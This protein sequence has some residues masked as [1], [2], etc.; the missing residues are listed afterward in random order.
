MSNMDNT[1][2]IERLIKLE[3]ERYERLLHLVETKKTDDAFANNLGIL[4]RLMPSEYK[5]YIDLYS[6]S[7]SIKK[8]NLDDEVYAYDYEVSFNRDEETCRF[9]V[10]TY[11][12]IP[13]LYNNV[14]KVDIKN[15][16]DLKFFKPTIAKDTFTDN[17]VEK[18]F[19]NS[20]FP[21]VVYS[22]NEFGSKKDINLST[23]EIV[24]YYAKDSDLICEINPN[25]M[26]DPIEVY[27]E[28]VFSK[29]YVFPWIEKNFERDDDLTKLVEM[30]GYYNT[31]KKLHNL[32]KKI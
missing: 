18:T 19:C 23:C 13:K 27:T 3:R 14:Y 15:K 22:K 20:K 26:F 10:L 31:S 7:F 11:L 4:V 5:T 6:S 9:I 12:N 29:D 1:N 21:S 30:A 16:R 24:R 32:V 25:F 28:D 2:N 17:F 8:Y